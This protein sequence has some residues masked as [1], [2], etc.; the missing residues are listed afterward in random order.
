M[1]P[2]GD[3]VVGVGRGGGQGRADEGPEDEGGD[4][5]EVVPGGL[6]ETFMDV[7]AGGRGRLPR[8][9]VRAKSVICEADDGVL[10]RL[11]DVPDGDEELLAVG[12]GDDAW[13][14]GGMRT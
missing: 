5:D 8:Q 12:R 7:I 6:E 14:T 2:E 3:R 1:A 9:H 13:R 4:D 11:V 10:E